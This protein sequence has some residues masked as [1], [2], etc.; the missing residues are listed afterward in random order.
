M[1]KEFF[2]KEYIKTNIDAT[3]PESAIRAVGV[4]MEDNGLVKST[5]TDAMVEIFNE[6]GPYIVIAP[7]LAMPHARPECGVN[8]VGA[9]VVSL[10][11]PINFGNKDNDPVKMLIGLCAKDSESHIGLLQN[12][13]EILSSDDNRELLINSNNQEEIFK[14][15]NN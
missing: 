4:L 7:G 12:L 11:N 6:H 1:K 8:K 5:Y 2:K 13:M 9:C 15:L 10:S 14:I 3:N